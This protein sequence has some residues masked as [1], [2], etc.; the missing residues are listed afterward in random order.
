M[1]RYF[2]QLL[3]A[4]LFLI[5]LSACSAGKETIKYEGEPGMQATVKVMTN[6]T[7]EYYMQ[8]YGDL[9]KVKYPNIEL[10]LVK[11]DPTD[12][13]TAIKENN[14]DVFILSLDEY[15]EFIQ[16][17]RL[18]DL[19]ILFA[20]EAFKLEGVHP[21]IVDYLRKLGNGKLFGVLPGFSSKAI[22]YNKDLFDKYGVPYPQDQMTWDELFQ[23]AARFPAEE[24][25]YGLYLENFSAL[26][27]NLAIS[28]HLS[29]INMKDRE[30]TLNTEAF[31]DVFERTLDAYASK[32]VTLP[33]IDRFEVYD[34]FISGSSAMTVDYNYYMNNKINW[35]REEQ[36]SKFHLNW[37]LATAPTDE[38][39]RDTSPYFVVGGIYSIN[40]GA[41]QKQAA[42]EFIKFINGEELAK[43]K[44]RRPNFS[45]F[46]RTDYI[47]NP[48]GKR[49]EAF[50]KLKPDVTSSGNVNYDLLPL[51][52]Y[53]NLRGIINS[54]LKA[55]A[56]G[57]KTLDEALASMQ[58]RGQRLLD[59][60]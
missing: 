20:N 8:E 46:T 26:A 25:V 5:L 17:G 29:E 44:S 54:E 55:V 34:P 47:Y 49:V 33:D 42:W 30:V 39:S 57:A 41:E 27:D 22:Y 53:T 43:S 51:G 9:F 35:A 59:R 16:D 24:G 19:D 37:D 7:E 3:A 50:Y 60:K 13:E 6:A 1:K 14:P 21:Y 31:R 23:L 10:Q 45:L 18:Y 4:S 48:E 40:A 58:E 36:G 28:E 32:A 12:P 56:A 38:A 15:R 2:A 52:T 11:Y